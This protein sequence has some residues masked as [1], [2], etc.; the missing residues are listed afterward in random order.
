MIMN[1]PYPAN[2]PRILPLAAQGI[3]RTIIRMPSVRGLRVLPQSP[4]NDAAIPQLYLTYRRPLKSLPN[5]VALIQTTAP[6]MRAR[7]PPI[8]YRYVKFTL[9]YVDIHVVMLRDLVDER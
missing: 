2:L 6:P 8:P 1:T 4:L 5:N 9:I 3:L 7:V